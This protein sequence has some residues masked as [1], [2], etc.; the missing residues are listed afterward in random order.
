MPDCDQTG[1]VGVEGD[2]YF[3]VEGF[4]ADQAQEEPW[5]L[6]LSLNL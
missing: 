3:G 2:S 5:N 6:E 1:I 4:P